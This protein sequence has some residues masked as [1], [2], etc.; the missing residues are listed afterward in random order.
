MMNN[1]PRY[2]NNSA[3]HMKCCHSCALYL[4]TSTASKPSST[5]TNNVETTSYTEPVSTSS[6]PPLTLGVDDQC[7][8]ILGAGSFF[9]R[10]LY[11]GDFTSICKTMWCSNPANSSSCGSAS[12]LDGTLCGNIK[13][14]MSGICTKDSK[15]PSGDESCLYGDVFGPVSSN[16][17]SCTDVV[18]NSPKDCHLVQVE[19]CHSCALYLKTTSVAQLKNTTN[20][21]GS[22]LDSS[23]LSDPL[24]HTTVVVF[25]SLSDQASQSDSS[26]I[27]HPIS[28][29]EQHQATISGIPKPSQTI[30]EYRSSSY[31]LPLHSSNMPIGHQVPSLSDHVQTYTTFDQATFPNSIVSSKSSKHTPPERSYMPSSSTRYSVNSLAVL[32]SSDTLQSTNNNMIQSTDIIMPTQTIYVQPSFSITNNVSFPSS[33]IQ[34]TASTATTTQLTTTTSRIDVINVDSGAVTHTQKEVISLLTIKVS[35]LIYLL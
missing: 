28:I 8:S 13:W 1:S 7:Q 9:C 16:G 20:D 6:V 29:S 2:C 24:E 21:R 35:I 10:E 34:I 4:K 31:V 25:P 12:A 22:S 33:Q 27:P 26:K 32:L 18:T 30:Y 15:A 5:Y 11:Q 19:C 17:W 23:I 14:C 3:I